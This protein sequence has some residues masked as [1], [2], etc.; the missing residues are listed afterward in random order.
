MK[1]YALVLSLLAATFPASAQYYPV[2]PPGNLGPSLNVD[3]NAG[4]A[5]TAT[6]FDAADVNQGFVRDPQGNI[7]P[8]AVP[9]ALGTDAVSINASG[10][11]AG[12][13]SD[14]INHGFVRSPQG[15]ITPFDPAGSVGTNPE[16]INASGAIAGYYVD[17][18]AVSHGFVRGPLG[19]ILP[20]DPPGSQSTSV[21]SINAS[22]AIVGYY[23]D[24]ANVAHGFVRDPL[25]N[26]TSFD[27]PGSLGTYASSIN[28]S[29]AIAGNYLGAPHMSHGFVRDPEG[30][31]TTFDP[32]G[33]DGTFVSGVNASGVIA[34]NYGA[35]SAIHGFIRDPQGNITSFDPAGSL[36]TYPESINASGAV[37][38]SYLDPSVAIH[39]FIGR[40]P[41]GVD[42]SNSTG[43]ISDS[44][45]Q[46]AQQAGVS[47][48]VVQAWNGG[49]MNTQAEAQLAGAQ[50]NGIATA[51]SIR[52][53][54]FVHDLAL[55]QL[56]E[57]LL[58]VG[59]GLTNLKFIVLDVQACC[60]EF[61]SWQPS[62]SYAE[63]AVIMDAANHIQE[64]TT[65]G[66]SGPVAPAW[67]DVGGVTSDGTVQ[68]K[69]TG[70]VVLDQ[71]GRVARIS[72]AVAA[73]EAYQLP[74]VI[75]TNGPNGNWQTITGNCGTGST[76]NCS[77]LIA[78][79]LWD[80]EYKGFYNGDGL[81]H[82]GDG[83]AGLVPFTPYSSTTWQARSG[84]Q[85][86]FGLAPPASTSVAGPANEY[87]TG[88]VIAAQRA[89]S[90]DAGL[91]GL[92]SNATLN[93]DYFDPALFQ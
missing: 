19:T 29:G 26:I 58:A 23:F 72:A 9:G 68:W 80:V 60:G 28:A 76:N 70:A 14:L 83:V 50:S 67:S 78:L 41:N 21:S 63:G 65:E 88:L 18:T 66:I 49:S 53:N 11:V 39:G 33:S 77:A 71:A 64:A 48:A 56:D 61:T 46:N 40:V 57:A 47:Y 37:A 73:I 17:V 52:L 62:T 81:L 32:A 24:A 43:V 13:Y 55:Y 79:P 3:I 54:Y 16:S 8:F 87:E 25:G 84:N 1:V 59:S 4:G 75:H 31:I 22:G 90:G 15:I 20:F 35:G 38:G 27:A 86:D 6:Y 93:L 12:F 74:L 91:F 44:V 7:T 42:V 36:F 45:W 89:C 10:A 34:G 82:C 69:D 85:Y 5:V 30:N 51:A 92:P 2:V